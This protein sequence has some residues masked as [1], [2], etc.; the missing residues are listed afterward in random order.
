MSSSDPAIPHHAGQAP[1]D[2]RRARRRQRGGRASQPRG[3]DI[4]G[5]IKLPQLLLCFLFVAACLTLGGGPG[6]FNWNTGLIATIGSLLLL[7]AVRGSPWSA[8]QGLP[9][10]ARAGFWAAAALPLLQLIPLPPAIWQNLPGHGL[11]A[12]VLDHFGMGGQWM[13]LSITPAETAYSAMMMLAML[14]LFMVVLDLSRDR[15]RTLLL[16]LL[17]LMGIATLVGIAQFA[18][19]GQAFQFHRFSHRGMLIGFFANKN[20]MALAL[21]GM[22]PLLFV[23]LERKL[24]ESRGAQVLGGLG[25]LTLLALLIATNSRAGVGLG[26]LAMFACAWRLYPQQHRKLSLAAGG[27]ALLAVV[28]AS[29]VPAIGDVATRFGEA[30]GDVRGEILARAMPLVGEYGAMGSG[31]GSF[32]QIYA[33]T[34][35]LD[36]VTPAY[37]NH[38][39]NDWLQLIIEAGL[40]GIAVLGLLL[41][42]LAASLRQFW[43]ERPPASA[44][45][46]RNLPDDRAMAWAG[47]LII[48]MFLLH[49]IADYPS[50][51]MGTLCVLVIA[52]AM[53]FR[54]RVNRVALLGWGSGNGANPGHN[55]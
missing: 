32:A 27:A 25:A 10:L 55:P 39:H 48:A 18:S 54:L 44:M 14:G 2:G 30:K 22:V 16:W 13:P 3:L 34:E 50:R 19:N 47:Y 24:L 6:E 20:H 35:K 33:P 36:W 29:L 49:S 11:R 12:Q 5:I 46:N 23:L 40:P 52:L 26:L 21:A 45:G 9:R 38:L 17:A 7:F 15:L 51:R 28:A 53:V 37:I 42:A 8:F 4:R 1:S 43:R 41:V 31:F